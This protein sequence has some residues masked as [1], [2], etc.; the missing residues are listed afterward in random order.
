MALS[1][2][3]KLRNFAG[4]A[5]NEAKKISREIEEKTKQELREKLEDGEKKINA[6]ISG[7][8]R[9]ETEAIKKE[10]SLEISRA[11]IKSR[12]EYFKYIDSVSARV[13]DAAAARLGDFIAS[14][15]YINYL[16]ECCANVI[17]KTGTDIDVFYMPRDEEIIITAV[18]NRLGVIFGDI[19]QTE[20][21]KD[22]TIKTGGLRFFAHEKNLFINDVFDEKTKRAGE[23][24]HSLIG[25]RF[26]GVYQDQNQNQNENEG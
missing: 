25:L 3:E 4:E 23:L 24:L 18:Q 19:S 14:G 1:S 5:M 6:R 16:V 8:I 26:T 9:Q 22:E 7:Y 10:M 20:F 17:K 2:D 21:K 11:D 13:F 12:Q 15:D